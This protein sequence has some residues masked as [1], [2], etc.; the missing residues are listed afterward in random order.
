MYKKLDKFAAIHESFLLK[1]YACHATPKINNSVQVVH[2]CYPITLQ[3]CSPLT[4]AAKHK[5]EL[6]KASLLPRRSSH[7]CM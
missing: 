7:S 1:F 2:V 3:K 5:L 4:I 6:G